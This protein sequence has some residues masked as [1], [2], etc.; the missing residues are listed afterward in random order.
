M[1]VP[2]GALDKNLEC[3]QCWGACATREYSHPY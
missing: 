2:M 3:K 1:H